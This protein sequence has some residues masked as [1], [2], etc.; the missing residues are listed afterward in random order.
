MIARNQIR[1]EGLRPA[2]QTDRVHFLKQKNLMLKTSE[3]QPKTL[4]GTTRRTKRTRGP[5][6]T[7][8][9]KEDAQ[10]EI[11]QRIT[12]LQGLTSKLSKRGHK[13]ETSEKM[14]G[15]KLPVGPEGDNGFL[16]EFVQR[17]TSGVRRDSQPDNKV[18][19]E[20]GNC[21]LINT[22][23]ETSGTEVIRPWSDQK[24]LIEDFTSAMKR[25]KSLS[26]LDR[27][28][29]YGE[30]VEGQEL[31]TEINGDRIMSRPWP[32]VGMMGGQHLSMSSRMASPRETLGSP[33]KIG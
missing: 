25:D 26:L 29:T 32:P 18:T 30:Y 28:Q 11:G 14:V 31:G 23:R 20:I 16:T 33:I 3:T 4:G 8:R 21:S 15:G 7:A 19:R 1:K 9:Q 10:L 27:D 6:L 13:T 22:K 24:I 2:P 17:I 12:F 5:K